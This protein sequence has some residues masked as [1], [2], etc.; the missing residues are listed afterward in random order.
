MSNNIENDNEFNKKISKLSLIKNRIKRSSFYHHYKYKTALYNLVKRDFIVKY[1]RS[2]LGIFWSV[3]NPLL[4][5]IVISAVFSYLFRFDIEYYPVYYLTGYIIFTM[6]SSSTSG[7]ISSI[8]GAAGLIKK[9]YMP[10]Y[11]FPIEKCLFEFINTSVSIIA[12]IVV[13]IWLQ[14]PVSFSWLLIPIPF[15]FVLIFSIGISFILSALNVYFRDV[16]HLYSVV[17]KVLIY[18]TPVFYP[19]S[20]LPPKIMAIMNYNPLYHFID[21]F[22]VL[23][24]DGK[25]PSL[26]SALICT[27]FA[28][29]TFLFGALV[30]KM[31]QRKFILYI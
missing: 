21:Y 23:V 4:M 14:L 19:V 13:L 3:L 10:K 16:G 6:F 31:L 17:T 25:I 28:L 18:A 7:A 29:G 30:F 2:V 27:A 26:D 1:R 20:I 15:L 5:M 8:I 12:L 22:R 24:I 11:L 9:M